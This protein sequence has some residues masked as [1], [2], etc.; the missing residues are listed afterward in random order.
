[1][2][3]NNEKMEILAPAG[4][5]DA[6][7][8]AVRCGADAI[9]LGAESFS[10]R[11]N[12][13]NF[14]RTQLQEAVEYCHLAGVAVHLA[15]NT[16]LFD[17]ELPKAL[18]LV[19]YACSLPVDAVIVQDWGLFSLLRSAAPALPLHCSTQMSIHT[20]AGAKLLERL[21]AARVVLSRELSLPEIREISAETAVE[22]EHFVHGALCMC[23][24][25]QCYFSAMLGSR[26]GNRGLCAQPCRL[27]FRAKGGTGYDLSLKDL[28]MIHRLSELQAAGVDSCKIEGR[29]K[30]PEY[31][32]AATASCRYSADGR[33][34]PPELMKN[35]E[36]V[37]SRSGFT[38]GYPDGK[39]GVEMFGTRTY[40]DVT[41]ASTEVFSSLQALYRKE[42]QRVPISMELRAL[43]GDPATLTVSDGG[44]TVTV[45]G[46]TV[47]QAVKRPLDRERCA[48]QL[49]K[50]GNT[51]FLVKTF[52]ADI[53]N[54]A[55]LPISSLNE[56]R[57]DALDQLSVLRKQRPAIPF[58]M[59]SAASVPHNGPKTPSLRAVCAKVDSADDLP[60]CLKQCELVFVPL[61]TKQEVIK[62]LLQR[63]FP[64]GVLLPRGMFGREGAIRHRLKDWA[65]LGIRHGWTG[66][67]GGVPLLQEANMAIH[68]GFS[69]NVTN[70][71]SLAF[72][73][74][75]GLS[76]CELSCE[77]TLAQAASIGGTL[78]RGLIAYG[79]LP[80]MLT[81][82]CPAANHP[83]GCR[84]CVNH[85]G[86]RPAVITD[87]KGASFPI[88]CDGCS[89]VFN[90]V[91]MVWSD[92]ISA[93]SG[94][95]FLVFNFTVENSV[96]I[97]EIFSA[98]KTGRKPTGEFT[99][100]LYR[101]GVE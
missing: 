48:Q 37:F 27:P 4:S 76:D 52:T 62:T 12:A 22:L 94:Q 97:D 15:V 24:S 7:I 82:N 73:Q 25:G 38:S 10:A 34:I 18:D 101:R 86:S 1:M 81:R 23:V 90:S 51:V 72:L 44:H 8:A 64:L 16:V 49:K 14:S 39:L 57:R 77:L 40:A 43:T 89:T 67:I 75:M 50:T 6:V 46:P 59:P 88:L 35:L 74:A 45:T 13:Q 36:S 42:A 99:R 92:R 65:A 33:P 95:D 60:D 3:K 56:L 28:S 26:S 11:G 78:P 32:A 71:A 53:S 2:R 58:T 5:M 84:G 96:E 79:R 66:N 63:G 29:M 80:L 68:G 93:F 87:R 55:A 30:R 85:G 100:G 54:D 31:V 91:P 83:D 17:K 61:H 41:G 69:L 21:G 98:Y 47:E 19:Q 9:Y 20:P 70:S